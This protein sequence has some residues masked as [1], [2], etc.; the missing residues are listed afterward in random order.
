[1]IKVINWIVNFTFIAEATKKQMQ[2][3]YTN[4]CQLM[5]LRN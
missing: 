2:L 3:D 4:T 1:M 5:C